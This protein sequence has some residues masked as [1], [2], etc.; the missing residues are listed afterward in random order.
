[1]ALAR[2]RGTY[3]HNGGGN[4]S[5]FTGLTGQPSVAGWALAALAVAAAGVAV[6]IACL[7]QERREATSPGWG[8]RGIVLLL[9]VVAYV[10]LLLTG[11]GGSTGQGLFTTGGTYPG[12][13]L[14][15]DP[16]IFAVAAIFLASGLLWGLFDGRGAWMSA[17]LCLPF[18][19]F[20][21]ANHLAAGDLYQ[22][23]SGWWA[24]HLGLVVA[25]EVTA[26]AVSCALLRLHRDRRD[27]VSGRR[28]VPH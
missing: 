7:R 1:M 18:L 6:R 8:L 11:A 9:A 13:N 14:P 2:T 4:D 15:L 17:A 12:A 10:P 22:S 16:A 20:Q 3:F 27:L 26:F 24:N 19:A 28:S 5:F 21:V 23:E 25:L